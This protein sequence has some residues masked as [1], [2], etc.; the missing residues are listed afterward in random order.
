MREKLLLLLVMLAMG[1]V[2]WMVGGGDG[3]LGDYWGDQQ[4]FHSL[5]ALQAN[6]RDPESEIIH[7]FL[8]FH[9]L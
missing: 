1:R 5:L 7:E 8:D 6:S 3:I 9:S 2:L 4:Q